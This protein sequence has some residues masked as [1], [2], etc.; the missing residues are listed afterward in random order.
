MF[1]YLLKRQ[2]NGFTF[3]VHEVKEFNLHFVCELPYSKISLD[4]T[5]NQYIMDA[6]LQRGKIPPRYKGMHWNSPEVIRL[7]S[8][9][10]I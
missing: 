9:K 6:L 2:P 7:F 1:V 5:H 4:G 3:H 8:F 10:S